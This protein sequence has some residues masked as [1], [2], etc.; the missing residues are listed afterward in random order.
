MRP[1]GP[2]WRSARWRPDPVKNLNPVATVPTVGATPPTVAR[3]GRRLPS[4]AAVREQ[5]QWTLPLICLL[6]Y[7]FVVTTYQIPIATAA[8]LGS[9]L[10]LPLAG[11]LRVPAPL[12]LFGV[13]LLWAG[14]GYPQSQFPAKSLESWQDLAKSWLIMLVAMN[15]LQTP[16][17][18]TLVSVFF[19]GCFALFPVRGTYFNYFIYR[20]T[21]NGRAA[22]NFIY[23]NA[24]DLA[25]LTLVP[26]ALCMG[27]CVTRPRRD[28]IWWA[29][30]AGLLMLPL[31]VVLTQSRGGIIALTILVLFALLGHRRRVRSF[32]ML[33]GALGLIAIVAPASVWQRLSGLKNVTA[34]S[35]KLAEVD[36]EG[37]AEQRFE[38]WKV[39]S[40]IS[41]DYPLAGVG[42]GV[43]PYVHAKYAARPQFKPT[44]RGLRDTHNTY[45][46]VLVE[47]GWPGLLIFLAMLFA[48]FSHAESTRRLLRAAAPRAAQQLLFMEL[49]IGCFLLSGVFGSYGHMGFL[50][51]YLS[52]MY[53]MAQASRESVAVAAS[54]RARFQMSRM[55]RTA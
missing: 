51:L 44:A 12:L 53:A 22:W 10:T 1:I 34:G 19:L 2:G 38:I 16:R 40:A 14:L 25:A 9:I 6:V 39:A 29:A 4:A 45:L 23:D 43:Y 5:I 27:I 28:W 46:N 47:T 26:I 15:T 24:N 55:P 33:L 48:S 18:I 32:A 3:S 13:Y 35:E 54:P 21:T 11:R 50:Y 20:G 7:I 42:I 52:L 17:H 31:M 37:S 36:P 49:G 41:L 8:A 30:A